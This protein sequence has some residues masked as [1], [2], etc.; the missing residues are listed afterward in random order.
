MAIAAIGI[1]AK[2]FGLGSRSF[3]LSTGLYVAFGWIGVLAAEPFLARLTT[4]VLALLVLG[5]VL[6][7]VGTVFFG[8]QRMRYQRAV[9]HGFVVAAA[10]V[11]FSAVFGMMVASG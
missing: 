7:T 9:W 1:A 6:Y 11:H 3:R 8:L 2:L 4:P 5:G 10:T